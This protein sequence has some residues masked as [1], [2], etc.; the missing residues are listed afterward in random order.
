LPS[1]VLENWAKEKEVLDMFAKH[2]LTGELMPAE[3]IEKMKAADN[4]RS[5][6]FFNRQ[7]QFANLD[8]AWHTLTE[9]QANE[10]QLLQRL[11]LIYLM[12]GIPQDTIAT[13]GRKF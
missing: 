10:A 5:A 13:N 6:S 8:M 7:I 4:F 1:Q 3:L 11:F 2:Y 12:V 9:E